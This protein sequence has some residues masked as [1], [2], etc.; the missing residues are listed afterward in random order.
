M[1]LSRQNHDRLKIQMSYLAQV[2]RLRISALLSKSFSLTF[3]RI[4]SNFIMRLLS[5]FVLL[6]SFV[7]ASHSSVTSDSA[8]P[9]S[10]PSSSPSSL[11]PPVIFPIVINTWPWT[12][13]TDS[14]WDVI[15]SSEPNYSALDA[16]QAGCSACEVL[17]CD[18]T[19]GWDG[20]PDESG[21]TTLDAMIMDGNTMDV[22]SVANLRQIKQAIAVARAVMNYT[23]HTLLSGNQATDFAIE[24]GFTPTSLT[25]SVAAK[26]TANWTLHHCQPNYR[27]AI[28]LEPN[29][30]LS[31]GPYQPTLG[32]NVNSTFPTHHP[33]T[34][35][36]S[37]LIS[38]FQSEDRSASLSSSSFPSSSSV[39]SSSPTPTST[40]SPSPRQVRSSFPHSQS[41]HDTIALI[42]IDRFGSMAAGT[43]T[44]GA[45]FK[46]PGRVGDSPVAGSGAYVDSD[47]GACGATG[48]GDVMMRFLP[49][50]QAVESMRN[51]MTPMQ[52]A[53]DALMRIGKKY[54]TFEG[55]IVVINRGGEYAGASHGNWNF[56]YSI[57]SPLMTQTMIVP[58]TSLTNH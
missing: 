3:C 55:A 33:T 26:M 23:Q 24:M 47:V 17:K 46:M 45:R 44:N 39:L 31:C 28:G 30:L 18:T 11:F 27:S 14:A 20:S 56:S 29:S 37:T 6:P 21:E 32:V 43:S 48:D 35:S 53:Q 38:N 4:E 7:L 49:C 2:F 34:N 58:V 41:S 10:I 16:V 52:A 8:L 12:R 13:A 25:G 5:L 40:A 51:G 15:T 19:V 36:A 22:G 54:P 57:R 50:Y 9:S 1:K 42:A